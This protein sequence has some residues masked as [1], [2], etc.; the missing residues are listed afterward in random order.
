MK[1]LAIAPKI[2]LPDQGGAAAPLQPS[3]YA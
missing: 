1:N 2:V 3:L